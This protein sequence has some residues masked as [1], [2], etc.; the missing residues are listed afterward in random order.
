MAHDTNLTVRCVRCSE[1]TDFPIIVR[2]ITAHS[3]P[4]HPQH[5]CPDCTPQ[6][7]R[8]DEIWRLAVAHMV[9]CSVCRG[10]HP[11]TRSQTLLDIHRTARKQTR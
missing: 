7:L 3:G 8:P 1:Q 6:L 11:C 2:W 10:D 5:A 4:D 9:G